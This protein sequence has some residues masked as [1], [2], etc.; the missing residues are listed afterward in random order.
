M[1]AT[2]AAF[3]DVVGIVHD[4]SGQA[5]IADLHQF[6][7]TDQDVPSSKIT[8]D[9]LGIKLYKIKSYLLFKEWY[10]GFVFVLIRKL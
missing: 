1:T 8:M 5:K 10:F 7:L 6:S 4:V 2:H 3:R 9:A